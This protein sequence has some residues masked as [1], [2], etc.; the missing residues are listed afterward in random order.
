M[1]QEQNQDR[2]VKREELPPAA[3][4]SFGYHPKKHLTPEDYEKIAHLNQDDWAIAVANRM[5]E[6]NGWHDEEW[7]REQEEE[8]YREEIRERI[9]RNGSKHSSDA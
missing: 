5:A 9:R 4:T 7:E 3:M 6:L 1:E 8:R 2:N